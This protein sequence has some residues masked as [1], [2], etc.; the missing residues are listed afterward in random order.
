MKTHQEVEGNI[1]G[2]HWEP[3]KNEKKSFSLSPPPPKT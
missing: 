2:T 1:V 3:R